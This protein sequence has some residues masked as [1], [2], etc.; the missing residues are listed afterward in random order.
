M[1]ML[2]AACGADRI[3]AGGKQAVT[4][5]PGTSQGAARGLLNE[6]LFTTVSPEVH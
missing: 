4:R 2:V 1:C 3:A 5:A 6:H